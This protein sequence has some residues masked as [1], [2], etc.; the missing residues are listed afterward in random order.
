MIIFYKLNE[1]ASTG[2]QDDLF[3]LEASFGTDIFRFQ[4]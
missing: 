2:E 3:K 1:G 4:L